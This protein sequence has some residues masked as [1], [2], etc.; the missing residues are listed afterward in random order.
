MF[1]V[2]IYKTKTVVKGRKKWQENGN[3]RPVISAV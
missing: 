3:R 1:P 2:V